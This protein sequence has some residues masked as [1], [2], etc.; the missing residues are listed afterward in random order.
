M[1]VTVRFGPILLKLSPVKYSYKNFAGPLS[2]LFRPFPAPCF[3][4]REITK[5]PKNWRWP[6]PKLRPL[7]QL[8][9]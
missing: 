1:R 7:F 4:Y 3:S 2:E 8:A 9:M 6:I 5:R